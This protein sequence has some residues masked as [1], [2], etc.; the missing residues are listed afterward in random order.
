M[1]SP[2]ARAYV[3]R[4]VQRESRR[5]QGQLPSPILLNASRLTDQAVGDRTALPVI[6]NTQR[7]TN[8]SGQPLFLIGYSAI[9]GGDVIG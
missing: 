2:R 8:D 6:P 7:L 3:Q 4:S 9:G 1:D 5:A